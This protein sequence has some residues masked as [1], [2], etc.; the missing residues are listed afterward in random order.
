[1]GDK[2]VFDVEVTP[3]GF[4]LVELPLA[5]WAEE[6]TVLHTD[7]PEEALKDMDQFIE[8]ALAARGRLAELVKD[9]S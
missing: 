1:M 2:F 5:T 7:D 6:Y 9:E 4:F 8:D 3:E